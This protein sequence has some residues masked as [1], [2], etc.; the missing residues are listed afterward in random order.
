M[1]L[2]KAIIGSGFL[3]CTITM[4][5]IMMIYPNW[6]V[7]TLSDGSKVYTGLFSFYTEKNGTSSDWVNYKDIDDKSFICGLDCDSFDS[8]NDA[9]FSLVLTA[10]ILM[11]VAIAALLLLMCCAKISR[12]LTW[13]LVVVS[14]V[15][16]FAA[17]MT[18]RYSVWNYIKGRSV[19]FDFCFYLAI[20]LNIITPLANVLV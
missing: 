9:V 3:A 18:Y 13:I 20:T 8:G 1:G 19:S 2:I 12:I 4:A 17:I 6:G 5:I 15:C 7:S 16:V 10:A 14:T 11:A